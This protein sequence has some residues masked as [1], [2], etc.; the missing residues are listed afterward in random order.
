MW[1]PRIGLTFFRSAA[2]GLHLPDRLT[3][4]SAEHEARKRQ[5]T[6]GRKSA[7]AKSWTAVLTVDSKPIFD[8]QMK[9]SDFI[10]V[11]LSAMCDHVPNLVKL[12]H[13]LLHR[14]LGP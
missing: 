5:A 11:Q 12:P 7:A 13:D 6:N 8:Q 3:P 1:R 2:R 10:F 14:L 9:A 4:E